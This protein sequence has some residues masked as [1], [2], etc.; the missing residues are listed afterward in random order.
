MNIGDAVLVKHISYENKNSGAVKLVEGRPKSSTIA[1]LYTDGRV[2]T[3]A[4]D[5]FEV[6]P[7]KD[8]KHKWETVR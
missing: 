4:G 5:V 2:K 1:A 6:Q 3:S 7:S 8:G